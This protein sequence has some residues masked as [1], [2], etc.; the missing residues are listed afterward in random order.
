MTITIGRIVL[1]KCTPETF[2]QRLEDLEYPKI[3]IKVDPTNREFW[4]NLPD[5][6]LF[7]QADL[8]DEL[9]LMEQEGWIEAGTISVFE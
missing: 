7:E 9:N 2:T 3:K 1:D 4:L 8:E 6:D 5:D